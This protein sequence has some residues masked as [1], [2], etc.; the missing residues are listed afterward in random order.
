MQMRI[1]PARWR[2]RGR[3]RRGWLAGGGSP[4]LKGRRSRVGSF[5]ETWGYRPDWAKPSPRSARGAGPLSNGKRRIFRAAS[6]TSDAERLA[7]GRRCWSW[8]SREGSLPDGRDY[9]PGARQ[10]I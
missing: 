3:K 4:T 6:G 8:T 2:N 9:R 5:S 7:E 1:T 10:R